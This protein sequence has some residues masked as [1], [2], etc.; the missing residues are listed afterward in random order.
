M[1]RSYL[2][3]VGLAFLI[4]LWFG[5]SSETADAGALSKAASSAAS[6]KATARNATVSGRNGA[7]R[8][9]VITGISKE[10]AAALRRELMRLDRN[11]IVR[12]E[13]RYGRYIPIT[14]IRESA[15]C[16]TCFLDSRTYDLHLQ[17]AYPKLTAADR[18]T[19]LGDFKAGQTFVRRSGPNMP[20][21]VA[22]ERLHQISHSGFRTRVG[23]KL[24]EGFT[25]HFSGKIYR[26]LTIKNHPLVYPKQQRLVSMMQARTG[27]DPLA[28]AYFSGNVAPLRLSLDRQLGR[29]AFDRIVRHAERGEYTAAEHI[30]MKGL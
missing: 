29:G 24:D 14:R 20:T 8:A 26:D 6:R 4:S 19:I 9:G 23:S 13:A 10:E 1:C 30:L 28:A 12:I 11:T 18:N 21:T 17:R 22:H 2:T 16:S 15:R 25:E 3:L 27:E 7:T 5:L